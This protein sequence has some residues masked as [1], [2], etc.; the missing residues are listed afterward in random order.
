MPQGWTVW[1]W[2]LLGTGLALKLLSVSCISYTMLIVS[3][4]FMA[5]QLHNVNGVGLIHLQYISQIH[6]V[7]G[8]GLI[9]L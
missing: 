4:R 7:N 5:I 8:V 3:S 6:N 2:H 9:H 1:T